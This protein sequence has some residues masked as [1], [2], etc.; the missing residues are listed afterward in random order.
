M[1][2]LK[3]ESVQGGGS[4]EDDTALNA[5]G[6][7]CRWA[8]SRILSLFFCIKPKLLE[9]FVCNERQAAWSQA[10]AKK[11]GLR[12]LQAFPKDLLTTHLCVS[13]AGYLRSCGLVTVIYVPIWAKEMKKMGSCP[14][15]Q[16]QI[17]AKFGFTNNKKQCNNKLCFTLHNVI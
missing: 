9:L 1:F 2:N 10:F 5:I 7:Y 16:Q 3:I 11:N 4:R 6:L 14:T 12:F 15:L 17:V 13:K 8:S